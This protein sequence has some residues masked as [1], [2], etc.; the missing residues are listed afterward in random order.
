MSMTGCFQS[1]PVYMYSKRALNGK[2]VG[3]NWK[4]GLVSAFLNICPP[5]IPRSCKIQMET[6]VCWGAHPTLKMAIASFSRVK[7]DGTAFHPGERAHA[8][9]LEPQPPAPLRGFLVKA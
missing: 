6:R 2:R 8:L 5:P 7:S 9:T 4:P 3:C 1:P